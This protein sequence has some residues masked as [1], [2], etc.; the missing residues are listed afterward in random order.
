MI[1]TG[2]PA[3]GNWPGACTAQPPKRRHVPVEGGFKVSGLWRFSSCVVGA[4]WTMLSAALPPGAIQ[5]QEDKEANRRFFLM[6]LVKPSEYEIVDNWHA[7]GLKGT[8]S[9]DVRMDNVF[10]PAHRAVISDDVNGREPTGRM[11]HDK[12]IY[13]VEFFLYFT[14]FLMGPILGMAEGALADYLEITRDRRGLAMPRG[15]IPADKLTVQTKV[16]ESGAEIRAAG[17]LGREIV[18]DHD[19]PAVV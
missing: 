14:T 4:D 16:A 8:G 7:A 11:I 10:V 6:I 12:Y 15:D 19:D 1:P 13:H 9:H 2:A 3:R 17:L 18:D 5:G